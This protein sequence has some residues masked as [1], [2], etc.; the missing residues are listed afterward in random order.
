MVAI[1]SEC[2]RVV[3]LRSEFQPRILK[4]LPYV[5]GS[6]RN[7]PIIAHIGSRRD[8]PTIAQEA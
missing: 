2:Q 8:D 5:V 7:D 4:D 6:C 3:F 1:V